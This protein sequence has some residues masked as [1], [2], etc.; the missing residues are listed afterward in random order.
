MMPTRRWIVLAMALVLPLFLAGVNRNIADAALLANLALLTVALVDL[1]ISPSPSVIGVQR[2]TSPVLSVATR[3]PVSLELRNS[4]RVALRVTVND[5]PGPRCEASGLP[6]T[7]T[8]AAGEQRILD[9]AVNPLRRGENRIG[10]VYLKFPTRLG[11]WCRQEVRPAGSD[12]RVYP[13][14]RAVHRYDLMAQKNRLA[15]LGVRSI[16]MPGQGREFERLRDYRFGDEIRQIDWKSTARHRTL[17][18]REYNVERNQNIVLMVDC[19]RFMRNEMD[20]ISYLDRALNAAIMLSWIALGQGDNVSLMAFS[21]RVERYIRPVRGKPGIQAILR[22]TYDIEV[23][24]FAADYTLAL[25]YLSRVQRNR[26]LVLL[27]TFVTD[28][29]QLDV[30]GESLRLPSMPWLPVCVLLQDVGLLEMAHR[31]PDGDVDA[32]HTA[33]AAQILT[34]Q[35]AKAASLREAGVMI[36][37]AP[38][39]L[40]TEQLIN[41]YLSI[42]TRGLI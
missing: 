33:A 23:S 18:S 20:G 8:L 29:L 19:G 14:I 22:S 36:L 6:Q 1:W 27:I 4:G 3:N 34:G 40:L 26:A 31:V 35:T 25:E 32:Y 16:R 9:Y 2:H 12:V 30:I 5:D 13:N 15:E 38:P 7:V 42:K 37:D 21:N 28:E 41:Q 17:I 39:D 11:L 10:P 24:R